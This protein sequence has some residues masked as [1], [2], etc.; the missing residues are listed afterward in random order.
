MRRL[1]PPSRSEYDPLSGRYWLGHTHNDYITLDGE[2]YLFYRYDKNT[3]H[4]ELEEPLTR[5][6]WWVPANYFKENAMP[7]TKDSAMFYTPSH[8]E[9]V[10]KRKQAARYDYM[11]RVANRDGVRACENLTALADKWWPGTLPTKFENGTM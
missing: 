4:V 6:L 9:T 7:D 5:I 1:V 2:V 3:D 10:K 8:N 11:E